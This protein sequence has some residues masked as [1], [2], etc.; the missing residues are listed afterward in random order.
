[1]T[2]VEW[3]ALCNILG[4]VVEGDETVA[5]LQEAVRRV[6]NSKG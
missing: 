5:E 2:K 4:L 3:Q 1:M 6:I